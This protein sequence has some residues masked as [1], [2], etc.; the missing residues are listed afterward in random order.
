MQFR[1]ENFN[2]AF[3]G[4]FGCHAGDVA[5]IFKQI[6]AEKEFQKGFQKIVFAVL[7]DHNGGDNFRIFNEAL[8]VSA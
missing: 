1:G 4:A 6:L 3:L 7:N 5:S 8:G 2:S